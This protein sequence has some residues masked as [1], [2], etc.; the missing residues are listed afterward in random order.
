MFGAFKN[1][2]NA[3]TFRSKI[4][5]AHNWTDDPKLPI[6]IAEAHAAYTKLCAVGADREAWGMEDATRVAMQLAAITKAVRDPKLLQKI[7]EM[8]RYFT[9]RSL[10]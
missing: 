5:L 9:Q 7:E 1:L 4:D 2:H 6:W 10:E 8:Y 3:G